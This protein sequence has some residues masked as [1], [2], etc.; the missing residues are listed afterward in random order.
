MAFLPAREQLA[1]LEQAW[2]LIHRAGE[3]LDVNGMGGLNFPEM[4]ADDRDH[5][6]LIGEVRKGVTDSLTRINRARRQIVTFIQ[7]AKEKGQHESA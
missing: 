5:V 2:E 3:I 6:Y 1:R 4:P 7:A